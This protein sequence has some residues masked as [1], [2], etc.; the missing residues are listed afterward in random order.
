[1]KLF[2]ATFFFLFVFF[3]SAIAQNIDNNWYFGNNAAITFKNG[4]PEEIKGSTMTTLEGSASISDENGQLLFYTDGVTVWNKK[5]EIMEN[6]KGLLGHRSATQSALILQ[7]IKDRQLYYL[8][9]VDEKAGVSGLNYHLIDLS[10]NNG[11]GS[12]V[13][14]NK[15][16]LTPVTEK[17]AATANSNNSSYWLITKQWN[18]ANLYAFLITDIG[19]ED[20]VISKVGPVISD[21]NNDNIFNEAIGQMTFSG[22]GKV[23]A[24][25]NNKLEG[26][27][28]NLYHFNKT[29]GSFLFYKTI[30]TSIY[31]YGV[32]FS[33]DEKLLY[34]TY[35]RGDVALRQFDIESGKELLTVN[36]NGLQYGYIRSAPDGK[37][38][39]TKSG[40]QLDIIENPNGRGNEC[41]YKKNGF[42][43]TNATNSFGLP[44][45]NS[46]VPPVNSSKNITIL[47]ETKSQQNIPSTKV[48]SV[49]IKQ[50]NGLPLCKE[51]KPDLGPDKT[52]CGEKIILTNSLKNIKIEWSTGDTS[53]QIK[54]NNSG[55]YWLTA[56][57]GKCQNADTIFIKFVYRE[58]D[59]K[60][61]TEFNPNNNGVNA[62]FIFS[63]ND[64]ESFEMKVFNKS[65]KLVFETHN[66]N[67]MWDGKKNGKPYP[68]GEYK[69]VVKY[70]SFC[71][72][73]PEKTEEGIVV[74]SK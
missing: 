20:V 8:F 15:K 51:L 9:T 39:I 37:I 21:Y 26:G 74:I 50:K 72:T 47:K 67:E 69:F 28:I 19:V 31:V 23:L 43:L 56:S 12:V 22:S 64:V 30:P 54:I 73:S 35:E 18:T 17:L 53:Q 45:K 29:T 71:P 66:P 46:Y 1:M 58:P 13:L 5:N 41:A 63:I 36:A 3:L 2:T 70:K 6:G 27:E 14:K 7:G 24:T 59:F 57:N 11:L 40:R 34:T 49:D 4:V 44:N 38:Y 42:S 48:N 55:Y 62:K 16:M 68:D 61:L 32:E 52:V 60:F 10:K 65:G 33:G 25:V